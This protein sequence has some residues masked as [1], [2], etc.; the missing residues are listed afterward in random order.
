VEGFLKVHSVI[1]FFK[2]RHRELN[3]TIKKCHWYDDKRGMKTQ[4]NISILEKAGRPFMG[5]AMLTSH[6]WSCRDSF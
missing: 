2:L 3:W 6:Y 4:V 5:A 1:N